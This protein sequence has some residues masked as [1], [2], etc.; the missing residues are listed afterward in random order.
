[1]INPY[2]LRLGPEVAYVVETI[3]SVVH[4]SLLTSRLANMAVSASAWVYPPAYQ[5]ECRRLQARDSIKQERD[6]SMVRGVGE[7][8]LRARRGQLGIE[9]QELDTIV[10][11]VGATVRGVEY[12]DVFDR[13]TAMVLENVAPLKAGDKQ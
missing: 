10:E 4:P 8:V 7:M 9:P 6:A 2:D 3:K 11:A 13:H 12:V 1:M 5:Q